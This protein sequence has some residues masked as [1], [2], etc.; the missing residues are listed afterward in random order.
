M[1][2]FEERTA[3]V[4]GAASGIG[5]EVALR[6]KSEGAKVIAADVG[7]DGKLNLKAEL[8]VDE[9]QIDVRSEADVDRVV[10]TAINRWGQI[11]VLVNAAGVMVAD[12][13]ADIHDE[14]WNKILDVN[15]T[16]AMRVCRAV[17]PHMRHRGRGAIVNVSSVAAFNASA[18][19]ASYAASK[20]GLVALTR[21]LANRYGAEGV[22]AN[23]V[24]PGWVRTRMSEA[25]MTEFAEANGTTVEQEFE[26]VAQRIAL[27]RVAVPREIATCV[28]FLASDDASFVTGAVLVA[29]GGART[30]ATSR[31]H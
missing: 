17:L 15:L 12:D 8:G 31:S 13:V 1:S 21:A 11:D 3:L 25:E 4:T 18:G 19:M 28:A 27:G 23:C 6:L 30:A 26:R 9:V 24:C 22:R 14:T 5:L 16:G 2:R 20:S 29:D 7:F 10:S